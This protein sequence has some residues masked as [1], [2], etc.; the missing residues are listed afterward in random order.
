VAAQDPLRRH[1]DRNFSRSRAKH[2]GTKFLNC[3]PIP[4]PGGGSML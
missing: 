4:W 1:S 3:R 2:F